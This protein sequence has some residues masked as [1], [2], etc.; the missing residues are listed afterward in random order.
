MKDNQLKWH[1]LCDDN[2]RPYWEAASIYH[3]DGSPIYFRIGWFGRLYAEES[4]Q[5]LKAGPRR[6]WVMLEDAKRD[7][8]EDHE[9]MIEAESK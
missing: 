3:D 7:L 1:E 2:D 5:E 6:T 8:Q 9:R 4:D